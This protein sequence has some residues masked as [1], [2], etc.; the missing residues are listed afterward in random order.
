MG[1]TDR[2]VVE[3]LRT[4]SGLALVVWPDQGRRAAILDGRRL[5]DHSGEERAA[6]YE[7][8][9]PLTVTECVIEL[10]GEAWLVQQ[11]GPA[12]AEP[13][14]ASTDLCGLSFLRLDG[15]EQR[16]IVSHGA[17]GPLPAAAEL[18]ELLATALRDDE[19]TAE[20]G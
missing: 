5:A 4:E 15:S 9:S 2:G 19:E 16:E 11:T 13:A 14:E 17:P 3:A 6:L 1:E 8:A 20:D 18:R 7:T 10:E 12:W